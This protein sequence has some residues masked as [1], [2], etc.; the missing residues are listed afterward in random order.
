VIRGGGLTAND[1]LVAL[2]SHYKDGR[3]VSLELT[4]SS[5]SSSAETDSEEPS[6]GYDESTIIVSTASTAGSSAAAT[7]TSAE[8]EDLH[9]LLDAVTKKLDQKEHECKEMSETAQK[10]L[11]TV[12]TFHMQQKQLFD[13]FQLLRQRYDEQRENLQDVLWAHCGRHHPE[14]KA[15]PAAKPPEFAESDVRIG[16]FA[17]GDVLGEGQFAT[18]FNCHRLPGASSPSPSSPS[19][20][21]KEFALKIIRKEKITT[22]GSLKHVSNE[23]EILSSLNCDQIVRIEE[24]LQTKSKLYIITEKGG[25]DLFE[26]FDEH[27]DGVCEAWAREIM[28]CVLR[29]VLY[30][31]A[32]GICHRDLKPENILVTFDKASGRCV[33]LKLCDFGLATRFEEGK[34]LSDFCGSPGALRVLL[35]DLPVVCPAVSVSFHFSHSQQRTNTNTNLNA[36]ANRLLCTGNDHPRHL[37]RRQGRHLVLRLHPARANHGPRKVL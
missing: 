14:L 11:A 31:H 3:S 2:Q 21:S 5:S 9:Q 25:L 6:T 30:I 13:E 29:G 10:A 22:F 16:D 35:L 33:D 20:S 27:P 37:L 34:Y 17:I 4:T 15:I 26:F 18:V 7:K 19:S 28:A 32:Q 8:L 24:I 12:Q 36:N 1:V 23:I